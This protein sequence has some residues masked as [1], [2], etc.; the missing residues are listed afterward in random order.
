MIPY[1]IDGHVLCFELA[2]HDFVNSVGR[3]EI[4]TVH[5]LAI[6]AAIVGKRISGDEFDEGFRSYVEIVESH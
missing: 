4:C 6:R 5:D 3:P 1:P 2:Y